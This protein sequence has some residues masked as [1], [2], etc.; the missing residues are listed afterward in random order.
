MS[1]TRQVIDLNEWDEMRDQR[2]AVAV[3]HLCYGKPSFAGFLLQEDDGNLVVS[4]SVQSIVG[5]KP[6]GDGIRKRVQTARRW[7]WERKVSG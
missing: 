3:T 5:Q 2:G 7:K 1:G 6:S 4:G